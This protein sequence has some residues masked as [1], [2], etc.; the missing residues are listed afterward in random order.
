M[1]K[2]RPYL[3][4]N[5]ELDLGLIKITNNTQQIGGK[6]ISDPEKLLYINTLEIDIKSIKID[7]DDKKFNLMKPADLN[8]Q[9]EKLNPSALIYN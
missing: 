8:I 5:L 1:L 2:D 6:W 9:I 4:G 3:V 7:Y